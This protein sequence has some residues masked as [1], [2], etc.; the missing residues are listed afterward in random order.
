M[1]V[2]PDQF[3]GISNVLFTIS[4]KYQ[5]VCSISMQVFQDLASMLLQKR[6]VRNPLAM[7]V[8]GESRDGNLPPMHITGEPKGVGVGRSDETQSTANV[9]RIVALHF[10]L[11]CNLRTFRAQSAL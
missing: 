7:G 5:I 1:N 4:V 3:E 8:T 6:P 2:I 10:N 9:D 11:E